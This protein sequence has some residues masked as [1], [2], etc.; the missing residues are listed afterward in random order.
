VVF[1]DEQIRRAIRKVLERPTRPLQGELGQPDTEERYLRSLAYVYAQLLLHPKI[2]YTLGTTARDRMLAFM[3][4]ISADLEEAI[5]RLPQVK[6]GEATYDT[7][8]LG[9]ASEAASGFLAF[10][11][12]DVTPRLRRIRAK[13]DKVVSALKPNIDGNRAVSLAMIED[14]LDPVLADLPLLFDRLNY[15]LRHDEQTSFIG[16]RDFVSRYILRNIST[17]LGDSVSTAESDG[18]QADLEELVLDVLSVRAALMAIESREIPTDY[19]VRSAPVIEDRPQTERAIPRGT[20]YLIRHVGPIENPLCVVPQ[21]GPHIFP[22]EGGEIEDLLCLRLRVRDAVTGNLLNEIERPFP[23]YDQFAYGMKL[24]AEKEATQPTEGATTL[25]VRVNDDVFIVPIPGGTL[26]TAAI[27]LINAELPFPIRCQWHM[28]REE[29]KRLCIYGEIDTRLEFVGSYTELDLTDPQNP[30]VVAYHEN[31]AAEQLGWKIGQPAL[32]SYTLEDLATYFNLDAIFGEQWEARVGGPAADYEEDFF[33]TNI[34]PRFGKTGVPEDQDDLTVTFE[35]GPSPTDPGTTVVLARFSQALSTKCLGYHLLVQDGPNRGRYQ[36]SLPEDYLQDTNYVWMLAEYAFPGGEQPTAHSEPVAARLDSR[37]FEFQLLGD[38]GTD[39][40]GEAEW[41]CHSQASLVTYLMEVMDRMYPYRNHVE[42][43]GPRPDKPGTWR[44]D[45]GKAGVTRGDIFQFEGVTNNQFASLGGNLIDALVDS[46][47]SHANNLDR[48]DTNR[49]IRLSAY[50]PT[51]FQDLPGYIKSS[52]SYW[53][54]QMSDT[55][56]EW[57]NYWLRGRGK[58]KWFEAL[59]GNKFQRIAD[60]AKDRARDASGRVELAQDLALV[61]DS[62][63][64]RDSRERLEDVE[65][66]LATFRIRLL[67]AGEVSP[68]T[69]EE[70]LLTY[71]PPDGNSSSRAAMNDI[72]S[73][74]SEQGFDRA[75]DL[76]MDLNLPEFLNLTE[77]TTSYSSATTTGVLRV[78]EQLPVSRDADFYTEETIDGDIAPDDELFDG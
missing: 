55:M 77:N 2:T 40:I 50:L 17:V 19:Y 46:D 5:I 12:A 64:T 62:L 58:S 21:S 53:H 26:P 42:M 71:S 44:F 38:W 51:V 25:L 66:A 43:V 76:L 16:L 74:L 35:T 31:T 57:L 7:K 1:T 22:L 49:R 39:I 75:R 29:M 33:G 13:L 72:L 67:S 18:A 60:T 32:P 68:I 9:E 37:H 48:I 65:A 54:R 28:G 3:R 63:L 73:Y 30:T 59:A 70:V 56:V 15:L 34:M 36:L 78:L 41:G 69:L 52:Y 20:N 8:S 61:Y 24:V 45:F 10:D 47:G 23:E 27:G 14:S 4:Q 6:L 11:Q